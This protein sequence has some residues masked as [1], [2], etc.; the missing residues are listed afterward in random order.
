MDPVS[1][2]PGVAE[3]EEPDAAPPLS[4]FE[5]IA[6]WVV[7]SPSTATKSPLA[8]GRGGANLPGGRGGGGAAAGS[9]PP[10]APAVQVVPSRW[11][12]RSRS[13]PVPTTRQRTTTPSTGEATS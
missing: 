1:S 12:T 9:P 13:G 7:A 3:P 10:A 2:V 8:I 4:S 11:I 6:T 5:L